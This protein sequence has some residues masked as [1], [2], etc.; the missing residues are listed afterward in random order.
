M[1]QVIVDN[2]PGAGGALGA[3]LPLERLL[4][5]ASRAVAREEDQVPDLNGAD[6]VGDGRFRWRKH[7]PELA[8]P[9]FHSAHGAPVLLH[10]LSMYASRNPP[11]SWFRKLPDP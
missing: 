4:A 11:R 1:W 6:V 9:I 2:R 8:Q 5:I 10:P 3:D 7:E